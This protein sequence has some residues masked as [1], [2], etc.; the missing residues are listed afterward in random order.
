MGAPNC[1]RCGDRIEDWSGV[2]MVDAPTFTGKEDKVLW[3]RPYCKTCVNHVDK[4]ENGEKRLHHIWMLSAVK[5]DSLRYLALALRDNLNAEKGYE[6]WHPQA[7]TDLVNLVILALP[8][9]LGI[10]VLQGFSDWDLESELANQLFDEI[11]ASN[12]KL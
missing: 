7:I 4:H 8:P 12:R 3:L 11:N 10:Q 6:R 5:T 2:V 1:Y 9:E